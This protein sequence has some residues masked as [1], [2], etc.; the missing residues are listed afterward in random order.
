MYAQVF[1]V[2]ILCGVASSALIL[3][4]HKVIRGDGTIVKL[5]APSSLIVEL[6]AMLKLFTDWRMLG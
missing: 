5:K 4:P 2:I 6:K 1:I 3:P